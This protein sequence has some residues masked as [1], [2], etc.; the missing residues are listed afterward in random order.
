MRRGGGGVVVVDE[1]GI[2]KYCEAALLIPKMLLTSL[3][4]QCLVPKYS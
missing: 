4:V 1:S 3:D 2:C